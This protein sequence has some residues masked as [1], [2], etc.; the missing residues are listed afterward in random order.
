MNPIN[1][2][3][4]DAKHEVVKHKEERS[5]TNISI[6]N[7]FYITGGFSFAGAENVGK[8][9]GGKNALDFGAEISAVQ[10]FGG[11][12]GV[13]EGISLYFMQP[14]GNDKYFEMSVYKDSLMWLSLFDVPLQIGISFPFGA[15]NR[16]LFS[17]FAGGY[18]SYLW[19]QDSHEWA[20]RELTDDEKKIEVKDADKKD[21][22]YWDYGLRLS[23]KLDIGHFTLGVDLSQS[24]HKMGFSAGA[25]IGV[26]LYSFRK[27]N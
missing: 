18:G 1:V 22:D 20:V 17:V 15:Y 24:L 25:N 23:A 5:R 10:H 7:A 3:L 9:F 2:V 12:F 21:K 11:V 13:R 4:K 26:K 14:N 27:K 16:H 8:I 19:N 6:R